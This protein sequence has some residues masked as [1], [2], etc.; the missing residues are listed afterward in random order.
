MSPEVRWYLALNWPNCLPACAT[1]SERQKVE[2]SGLVGAPAVPIRGVAAF[3]ACQ[4]KLRT[5]N[6]LG[7]WCFDGRC[8]GRNESAAQSVNAYRTVPLHSALIGH[9]FY[10][11]KSSQSG[12]VFCSMTNHQAK[13]TTGRITSPVASPP[14]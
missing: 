1:Q 6:R 13:T 4:L 11:W 5:S 10:M 7:I 2:N 14:Q 9:Q 3:E 8:P 12:K